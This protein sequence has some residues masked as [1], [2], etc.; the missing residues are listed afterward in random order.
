MNK[1]INSISIIYIISTYVIDFSRFDQR[2]DKLL[3]CYL[4]TPKQNIQNK[5]ATST[6]RNPDTFISQT[7][8]QK[9]INTF[10]FQINPGQLK[11][12]TNVL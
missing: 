12:V 5:S 9:H 6:L 1:I 2:I 10:Y 7:K 4:Y 8:K 11:H 3:G